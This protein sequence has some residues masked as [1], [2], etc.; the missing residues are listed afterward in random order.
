MSRDSVSSAYISMMEDSL[1]KKKSVLEK[2][3]DLSSRQN[4][5]LCAET[6]D[7]DAFS[8][9]IDQKG[10][11][12][13]ELERLDS[14]FDKLYS[15]F[16]KELIENR[17]QYQKEIESMKKLIGEIT[18]LSIKIQVLEKK[19]DEKFKDYLSSEK[20]RIRK[21]NIS[22]QTAMGYV[23]NMAESHKP[24]DSYFINEAK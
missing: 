4:D 12:I 10:K 15:D 2:V 18:D 1:K 5:F 9:S 19:N 7:S 6:L 11:K 24:G 22:Q 8:E 13:E 17:A 14:G 3:Y 20:Q 16:E 23:R 21:A